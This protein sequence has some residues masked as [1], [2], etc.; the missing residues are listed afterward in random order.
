MRKVL[1]IIII[2]LISISVFWFLYIKPKTDENTSALDVIS[3]FFPD[4]NSLGNIFDSNSNT[5]DNSLFPDTN[6][7]NSTNQFKQITNFPIAGYTQF[8][9]KKEIIVN[10]ANDSTEKTITTVTDHIIRY[11]ARENGYVYERINDQQGIQVS[12]IYIP[13]I[14]EAYFMDNSNTAILRFLRSDNKTV[15]TY[16]VPIPHVDSSGKRIQESGVYFADNI[17]Y[18]STSSNSNSILTLTQNSNGGVITISDSKNQNKRILFSHPFSE[19]IIDWPSTQN[20]FLQTKASSNVSGFLYKINNNSLNKIIGNISGLTTKSSPS[21]KYV[22]YSTSI[23]G[24]V[25][26]KLLDT[27]N[28][29]TTTLNMSILPEKCTWLQNEDLICAGN[30]NMPNDG[31]YPDSWYAGITKL[32]DR[33]YKINTSSKTYLTLYDGSQKLFDMTNLQVDENRGILYFIDKPTGLLWQM[34]I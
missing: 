2:I 30:T 33:V 31:I 26:T 21:G 24:G 27:E 14:Y 16:S 23:N 10:S 4:T 1:L 15:A 29:N 25:I 12:N 6:S 9:L 22:L 28:N 20:I 8:D 7:Q 34:S 3:S 18:I 19:W 11:V 5:T 13:N 17:S 32:N